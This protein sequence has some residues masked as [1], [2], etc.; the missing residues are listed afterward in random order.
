MH[1]CL[2]FFAHT[3]EIL[4]RG[5]NFAYNCP[6]CCIREE[7]QIPHGTRYEE[8]SS[9]HAEQLALIKAPITVGADLV[10]CGYDCVNDVEI[11]AF[12]CK[13]CARMILAAGIRHILTNRF[14]YSAPLLCRAIITA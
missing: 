11:E 13:I 4:G 6:D 12:P 3:N 9:V 5:A 10:L 2:I 1:G 8:C 7:K 14:V